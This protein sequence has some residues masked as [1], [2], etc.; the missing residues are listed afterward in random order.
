MVDSHLLDLHDY[1]SAATRRSGS[2]YPTTQEIR[3]RMRYSAADQVVDSVPEE[4][5]DS[6]Y[7]EHRR[8]RRH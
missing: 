8:R 3:S 6:D 4:D 2:D 7:R 1:S 5:W